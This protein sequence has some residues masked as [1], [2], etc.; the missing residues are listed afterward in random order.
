MEPGEAPQAQHGRLQLEFGEACPAQVAASL[1]S[2]VPGGEAAVLVRIQGIVKRPL[3]TPTDIPPQPEEACQP[4]KGTPAHTQ[5]SLKHS[6]DFTQLISFVLHIIP[7]ELVSFN[8]QHLTL[9]PFL[10]GSTPTSLSLQTFCFS[11]PGW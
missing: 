9:L 1:S 10:P 7:V 11:A 6:R 4:W 8:G 2:L 5:G 3:V